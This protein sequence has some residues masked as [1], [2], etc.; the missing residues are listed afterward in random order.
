M[1]DTVPA[2]GHPGLA[3]PRI[4][5]DTRILATHWAPAG[6]MWKLAEPA[7]QLDANLIRLPPRQRVDTHTEPDLDVLLLV[8]SGDG[9]LGSADGP[10]PL[11]EGILL[12]L[13]RGSTRSLTA[14]EAGL[15]Y[16]TVHPRRPG[17]QIAARGSG[18]HPAGPV[19][20]ADPPGG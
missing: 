8:V 19:T 18:T 6:A 10:Q 3:A 11:A 9:I 16:L 15:S 13:P 14:G 5:C 12:W 20:T 4:L 2:T 7:R 17:L 1:P